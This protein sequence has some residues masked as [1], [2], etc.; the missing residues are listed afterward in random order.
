[1]TTPTTF[2]I[3]EVAC[4]ES[5]RFADM[6]W[7]FRAVYEKLK[8]DDKISDCVRGIW[9]NQKEHYEGWR[10]T[11]WESGRSTSPD[12]YRREVQNTDDSLSRKIGDDEVL[13]PIVDALPHLR[14]GADAKL[15]LIIHGDPL[16]AHGEF[17]I[18][19]GGEL[20]PLKVATD[21]TEEA[22]WECVLL[23][24]ASQQFFL[25]WHA[26]YAKH[27]I[28]S[29]VRKDKDIFC[30]NSYR[31]DVWSRLTDDGKARLLKNDFGPAV[32]LQGDHAIVTYYIFSNFGGLFKEIVNV[33]LSTGA[34][35]REAE[36]ENIIKYECGVIF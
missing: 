27:W 26:G 2:P 7:A 32:K 34:V 6:L 25:G 16:G 35:D 9:E 12:D 28:I 15:D 8:Y 17:K 3:D 24:E 14:L 31:S 10:K 19:K 33:D 21:G 23:N 4:A 1:M 13:G 30:R 5:N 20:L 18:R 29:D 36:R 11:Q 22:A